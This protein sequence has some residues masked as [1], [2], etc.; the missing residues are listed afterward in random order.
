MH[1]CMPVVYVILFCVI[2]FMLEHIAM[3]LLLLMHDVITSLFCMIS[4]ISLSFKRDLF[5]SQLYDGL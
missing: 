4:P 1:W 2:P 5:E 3:P